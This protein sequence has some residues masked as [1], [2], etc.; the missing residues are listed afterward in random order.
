MAIVQTHGG[1]INNKEK[2]K[3]FTE[4]A[5]YG[6]HQQNEST[7]IITGKKKRVKERKKEKSELTEIT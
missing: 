1:Q 2:E 6:M 5:V 3:V 7:I 4:D